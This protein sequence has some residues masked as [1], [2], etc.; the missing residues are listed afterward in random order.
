MKRALA[1][2]AISLLLAPA[3]GADPFK[4]KIDQTVLVKL[5]A[6]PGSIV[7]GNPAIASV[8]LTKEGGLLITGKKSGETNIIVLDGKGRAIWQNEIAVRKLADMPSKGR[9]YPASAS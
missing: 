8:A 1:S 7:V 2:V 5:G 9:L 4:I 6:A 3:A